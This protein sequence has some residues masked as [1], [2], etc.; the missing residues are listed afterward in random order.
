MINDWNNALVEE[1]IDFDMIQ[2]P[3]RNYGL[4]CGGTFRAFPTAGS[5]CIHAV[6]VV[7]VGPYAFYAV[8]T[9][10]LTHGTASNF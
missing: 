9:S 6:L 5:P 1:F 8:S 3:L 4:V 10:N 2:V 7:V